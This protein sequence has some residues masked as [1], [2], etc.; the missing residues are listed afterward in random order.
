MNMRPRLPGFGFALC[1]PLLLSTGCGAAGSLKLGS[2]ESASAPQAPG[3]PA[4]ESRQMRGDS[5]AMAEAAPAPPPPQPSPADGAATAGAAAP[6]ADAVAP[7]TAT[8]VVAAPSREM[9]DIEANVML[10]VA[11]VKRGV[12]ALHDLAART[13]GVVTAER[14]DTASQYGS[15]ELTLRIPSRAAQAVF[16]DLEKLG[17]VLN[18]TVTARD[19]G[20]EFFD[21]NLRL[22]SL[23]ATLRRYEEILSKAGKVEEILRIEQELARL[24]AE[25]EQVKGDLRWLS[26]RAARATL[27]VSLRERAPQV[28]YTDE[29]EAKFFPGLRAPLLL[30]F[31][32]S[33][34]PLH[35]GGGISVRFARSFSLDLDILRRPGSETRGPDALVAS[36]GGEIYSELLGDGQRR[37]L[38]PY[39]GFR[40]GYGRFD[41]HDQ[42]VVG[43]TAGVELFNNRWFDLDIETRHYL[44][45]GGQ[46]GA[47]YVLVPA[48]AASLAF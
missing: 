13:G 39:L 41:A 48:L 22:S 34:A 45:F 6:P 10:Q 35:V 44:A 5:G 23:S 32:R 36:A 20:K 18:Q 17:S 26:D 8:P 4:V 15:A 33:E 16:D 21:A 19:I 40:A 37:F 28:V 3:M 24:R 46:L 30:D 1:A 47:H 29:P 14:I 31:G 2:A 12:K 42:A 43:A 9:L 38:N 25:I 27:H 11:N 7:S